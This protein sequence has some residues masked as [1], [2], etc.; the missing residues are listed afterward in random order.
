MDES[1]ESIAPRDCRLTCEE[2]EVSDGETTIERKK[3]GVGQE[4]G[5]EMGVRDWI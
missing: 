2:L 5:E 1:F 4:R 3:Q